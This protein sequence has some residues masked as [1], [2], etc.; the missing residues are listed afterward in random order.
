MTLR[1]S[2][3]VSRVVGVLAGFLLC[4][5]FNMRF[6]IRL[7]QAFKQNATVTYDKYAVF[8]PSPLSL[9]Q[10]S[11]FGEL[12]TGMWIKY[13]QQSFIINCKR[14][15]LRHFALCICTGIGGQPFG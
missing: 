13:L 4:E 11:E 10:L 8:S 7:L 1:D 12:I 9:K 3:L 15:D 6:A 14:V 5:L 2:Q